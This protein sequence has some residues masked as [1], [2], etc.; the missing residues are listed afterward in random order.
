MQDCKYELSQEFGK[1]LIFCVFL[2]YIEH[3]KKDGERRG[4][5]SRWLAFKDVFG[6]TFSYRWFSPFHEGVPVCSDVVQVEILCS[7]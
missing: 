1:Q 6:Q 7:V 4:H 2:Q 3:L 5:L